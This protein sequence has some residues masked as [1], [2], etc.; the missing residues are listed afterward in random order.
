[1]LIS[2]FVSVKSF[3][4]LFSYSWSHYIILSRIEIKDKRSFYKI[5]SASGN[6]IV[7]F[8]YCNLLSPLG[9]ARGCGISHFPGFQMRPNSNSFCDPQIKKAPDYRGL[10]SHSNYLML[11]H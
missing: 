7:R 1:M 9:F 11:R 5:E 8:L 6:W 3:A 4:D 10:K 2:Q